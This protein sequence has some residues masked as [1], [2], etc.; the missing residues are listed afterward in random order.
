MS[1]VRVART[2]Q[3]PII[4]ATAALLL[5]GCIH[6]GEPVTFA[7]PRSDLDTLAYGGPQPAPQPAVA[8]GGGAISALRNAFAASPRSYAPEPVINAAAPVPAPVRRHDAGYK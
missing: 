1:P 5:S 8:Y 7:Q 2:F 6:A 3:L 4:A